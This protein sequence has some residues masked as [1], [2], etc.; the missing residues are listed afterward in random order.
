MDKD[1][2][3]LLQ[4]ADGEPR[5]LKEAL[6]SIFDRLPPHPPTAPADLGPAWDPSHLALLQLD[7][8]HVPL[9]GT[10]RWYLAEWLR[11]MA[12]QLTDGTLDEGDSK[13]GFQYL[14]RLG[15]TRPVSGPRTLRR[16]GV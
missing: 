7:A 6:M 5:W 11:E 15:H 9:S 2:L 8:D 3:S 1:P 10:N 12:R 14:F 16:N 4:E 13:E